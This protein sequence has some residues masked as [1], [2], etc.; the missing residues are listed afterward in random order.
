M[1]AGASTSTGVNAAQAKEFLGDNYDDASFTA[2]LEASPLEGQEGCISVETARGLY[3]K[4]VKHSA[5][6]FIKPHANT[7]ATQEFVTAKIAEAGLTCLDSGNISGIDID[8]KQLIDNHYYAIASK[9]TLLTPDQLAVPADKFKDFFNEE[10]ATVLAE[11]RAMNATDACKKLECDS[12]ELERLW[13]ACEPAGKVVKFGGGFYCGLL[14]KEGF[15]PIYS[16]NCFFTAMR[17]KFCGPENSIHYYNV[18]WPSEGSMDWIDFRG[19]FIGP[20]NPANADASS[21]RGHI[22]ANWEALG[23]KGECSMGDNGVHASASPLEGLSEK[24]NWLSKGVTDEPFGNAL[25]KFGIDEDTIKKWNVDCR[26][27]LA[28]GSE[29]SIFDALEDKNAGVCLDICSGVYAKA[30]ETAPAVVEEAPS[31]EA[32]AEVPTAEA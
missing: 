12:E 23:L 6:I 20:T 17:N 24:M 5:L 15:D 2:A 1:G 10:W 13:R 29:S 22:A 8:S 3:Y 27:T 26:V 9:A 28:D 11:G 19:K 31:A 7:P 30:S 25:L 32:P 18:E 16:F 14:Q 4:T 21:L